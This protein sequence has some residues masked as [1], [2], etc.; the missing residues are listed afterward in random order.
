MHL[1]LHCLS[2]YAKDILHYLQTKQ[3]IYILVYE[4]MHVYNYKCVYACV[5][6][7]KL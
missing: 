7:L 6:S 4:G 1:L 5:F 3:F 2:D